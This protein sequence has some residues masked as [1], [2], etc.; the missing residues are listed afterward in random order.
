VWWCMPVMPATL[1]QKWK[2][3]EFEAAQAK[4]SR[5]YL[6]KEEEDRSTLHR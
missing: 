4:V 1:R 3:L 6:L 5:P 2:D